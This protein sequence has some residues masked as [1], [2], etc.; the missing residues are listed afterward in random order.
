MTVIKNRK[1]NNSSNSAAQTGDAN[2]TS[3]SGSADTAQDS[4]EIVQ[5]EI[6]PINSSSESLSAQTP[7]SPVTNPSELHT[8]NIS[9]S[10]SVSPSTSSTSQTKNSPK[11]SSPQNNVQN[12]SNLPSTSNQPTA[13]SDDETDTTY[14]NESYLRISDQVQQ[15]LNSNPTPP[16]NH[17]SSN[18]HFNLEESSNSADHFSRGRNLSWDELDII[19]EEELWSELGIC[20]K[21]VG[22]DGSCLFRSVAHQIY[23]DE[24]FHGIVRQHCCDYLM[25]NKDYFQ[26]Y[27]TSGEDIAEYIR[28]KR[29]AGIF[30]NHLEV[31]AMSEMYNRPFEVYEYST[32]PLHCIS[33]RTENTC[34]NPIRVSYH[35]KCHFNSLYD[36]N[37]SPRLGIGLGLNKTFRTVHSL[38]EELSKR[39]HKISELETNMLTDKIIQTDVELSEKAL[40]NQALQE[41]MTFHSRKRSA[42]DTA[43]DGGG[44]GGSQGP[45][46][47]GGFIAK[48][49]KKLKSSSS[50]KNENNNTN[51]NMT[52]EATSSGSTVNS[53]FPNSSSKS[54]FVGTVADDDNDVLQHILELSKREF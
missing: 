34:H 23:G 42:N 13:N 7:V 10:I 31:Q 50:V 4:S 8:T 35:R 18:Q 17:E 38:R 44:S 52:K 22:E 9:I 41:S 12:K 27:L 39:E 25:K 6:A 30:G 54:G 20:I 21:L 26:N 47:D 14:L 51:T 5:T 1:E 24:E 15:R 3:S 32:L 28:R 48:T 43:V 36:P 19:F 46:T 49:G 16:T 40:M 37:A 11:V 45:S 2:P 29:I 53:S 33:R